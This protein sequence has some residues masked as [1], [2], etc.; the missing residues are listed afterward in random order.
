M[1]KLEPDKVLQNCNINSTE[2]NFKTR[3][4]FLNHIYPVY[5]PYIYPVYM[6][7][8][9]PVEMPH[10]SNLY[11]PFKALFKMKTFYLIFKKDFKNVVMKKLILKRTGLKKR[12]VKWDM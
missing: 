11:A 7:R 6:P 4:S 1:L 9:Y 10:L 3:E 12:T 8:I 5:M 2:K